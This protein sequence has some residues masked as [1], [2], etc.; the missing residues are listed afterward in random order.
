MDPLP[1]VIL[2]AS[3]A[4][5]L[6]WCVVIYCGFMTS[7]LRLGLVDRATEEEYKRMQLRHLTQRQL[8]LQWKAY[9]AKL[10]MILA[11]E[12]DTPIRA[13]IWYTLCPPKFQ[14]DLNQANE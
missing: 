13:F 9:N 8:D 12:R 5:L 1:A 2:L 11:A 14:V 7:L 3:I 4:F 10:D 6:F